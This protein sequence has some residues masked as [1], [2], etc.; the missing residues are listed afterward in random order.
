MILSTSVNKKHSN[1]IEKVC[2]RYLILS[3]ICGLFG[4][5]Y[6]CFSHEVYSFNMIYAFAFLLILGFVPYFVMYIKKID[7][8]SNFWNCGTATLT[9]GSIVKGILDIYGTTNSLVS[10]YWVVGIALLV[11][12]TVSFSIEF[13]RLVR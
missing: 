12:G 5:I 7:I 3:L 8:I 10:F 11:M 4:A 2:I 1:R 13:T 6:E 9:M